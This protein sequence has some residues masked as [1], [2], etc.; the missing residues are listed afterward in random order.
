MTIAELERAF[1]SYKRI[2]R[3]KAQEKASY[4][5]ILANLI[6]KSIARI[7]SSANTYPEISEVY[8]SLFDTKEIEEKKS[9]QKAEL[10]AQR[11]RQYADFHNKKFKKEVANQN[12]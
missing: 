8:P 7:Y 2:Q 11:F 12:E 4:D 5:Y 3:E 9:A 6:G 1:S 10:S